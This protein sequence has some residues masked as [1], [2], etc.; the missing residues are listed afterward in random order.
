MARVSWFWNGKWGWL[1]RRDV[2]I[3]H[4]LES[5]AVEARQGGPEGESRRW[6][7]ADETEAKDI[8]DQ[9]IQQIIRFKVRSVVF[10]V[11]PTRN[12]GP[13]DAESV[14][15]TDEILSRLR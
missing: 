5:W 7:A 10:E 4:E 14:L 3:H 12:T 11:S 2:E 15:S 13:P 8:A 9:L 1:A 6:R